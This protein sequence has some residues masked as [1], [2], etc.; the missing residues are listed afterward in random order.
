MTYRALAALAATT[1]VVSACNIRPRP[2]L[3][4]PDV[5]ETITREEI[6][7][8]GARTMWDA[9]TRT[10]KYTQFQES[11]TGSP[12]RI[13]RRGASSI[14]LHEDMPILI[15]QVR[16]LDVTLLASLRA[17]D[18]DRIQVLTGLH[19]TTY[20]GTNAGDGIILIF[21]RTADEEFI[22]KKKVTVASR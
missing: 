21:T 8:T 16:V 22:D 18:I 2:N 7:E 14:V 11:G 3:P 10:V 4:S 1:L 5:G 17:D 19:A 13:R 12:Q 15:D 20:Y 9:L 6:S